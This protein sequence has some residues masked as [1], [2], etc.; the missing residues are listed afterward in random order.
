M[1]LF[2]QEDAKL[3]KIQNFEK[4]M[5]NFEKEMQKNG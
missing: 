2:Q 3:L 5:Q 1:K 4:K